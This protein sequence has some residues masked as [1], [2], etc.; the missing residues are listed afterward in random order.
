MVNKSFKQEIEEAEKAEEQGDNLRASFSYKNA[1]KKAKRKN[2]KE[3]IKIT[4]KKL[5]ETSAKTELNLLE[6]KIPI[7][8]DKIKEMLKRN[9]KGSLEETLINIGIGLDFFPNYKVIL[10]Q[11]TETIPITYQFVSMHTFDAKGYPT[12]GGSDSSKVWFSNLY[13]LNLGCISQLALKPIFNE[14]I[15][16]KWLDKT[17]LM[18]FLTK[19]NLFDKNSVGIIETGIERY[20]NSDYISAL[21]ILVPQLERFFMHLSQLLGLDITSLMED[22]DIAI[23]NKILS[24]WHL[25]SDE[26][27]NVWGIDLCQHLKYVFYDQLGYKLRHKIAHGE[28]DYAECNFDNATLVVYFF[29][30]LVSRIKIVPVEFN[31]GEV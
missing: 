17:S 12:K 1:L 29:I 8:S 6:V 15:N 7:K 5:I 31:N 3:G 27:I 2:D 22:D 30:A 13:Q 18:N 16:K 24:I 4:K 26:F 28:I 9:I 19:K 11:S 14:L 10:D 23:Q 21:H 25:D 20:F